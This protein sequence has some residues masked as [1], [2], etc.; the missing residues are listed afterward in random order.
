MA[1]ESSSAI[2]GTKDEGDG[3]GS[4]RGGGG[5]QGPYSLREPEGGGES[6]QEAARARKQEGPRGAG[7]GRGG[8]REGRCPGGAG[9]G[10][11][12]A[13]LAV[14]RLRPVAEATEAHFLASATSEAVPSSRHSQLP[15]LIVLPF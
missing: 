3:G 15:L 14:R 5:G 10:S 2:V 8:A 11:Q 1:A 13:W 9:P 4:G 6:R 7:P 12:A